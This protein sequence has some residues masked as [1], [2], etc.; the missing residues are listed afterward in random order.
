MK[1]TWLIP[2]PLALGL[3]LAG[4][5]GAA[6]PTAVAPPTRMDQ[7]QREAVNP[8]RRILEAATVVRS[9]VRV[10]EPARPVGA[11]GAAPG[12]APGVAPGVAA[13]TGHVAITTPTALPGRL[14]QRSAPAPATGAGAGAGPVAHT[15]VAAAPAVQIS[16]SPAA[17]PAATAAAPPVAVAGDATEPLTTQAVAADDTV[18]RRPEASA[19]LTTAS[20]NPANPAPNPAANPAANPAEA[21]AAPA[22]APVLLAAVAPA[23]L[24]SPA[25]QTLSRAAAVAGGAPE[26]LSMVEPVVPARLRTRLPPELRLRLDLTIERDGSVGEVAVLSQV[27]RQL[28][29]LVVGAVRQWRYAPLT[30]PRTHKVELLLNFTE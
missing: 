25:A 27:D 16:R 14:A 23:A 9:K 12:I 28:A 29:P 4:A 24:P 11:A 15:A 8:M 6:E 21:G 10:V 22:E 13:T 18:A 3:L 5:A 26:M 19:K 30:E 7:V 20:V 1:Y 2:G 17:A